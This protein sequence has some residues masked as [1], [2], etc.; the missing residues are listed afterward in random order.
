MQSKVF[1]PQ[2]PTR[3]DPAFNT[4]V[5]VVDLRPAAEFGVVQVML[6]ANASAMFMNPLVTA[7][8]E[9]LSSFV[10]ERDYLLAV[11]D[12]T[13]IAICGAV[14]ARRMDRFKM[15]KWDKRQKMYHCVEIEL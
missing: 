4:R 7:L 5:P 12:P 14:L 9:K 10:S 1:V 6:P 11:G 3:F 2:E 13:L 15:L 8:R